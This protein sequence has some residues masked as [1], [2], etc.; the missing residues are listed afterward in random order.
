M[1]LDASDILFFDNAKTAS[2]DVTTFLNLRFI[3]KQKLFFEK[4]LD[5][6]E[7]Q[8]K[9]VSLNVPNFLQRIVLSIT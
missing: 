9:I 1:S 5:A 8:V 7:L 3:K 4:T 2:N 6:S